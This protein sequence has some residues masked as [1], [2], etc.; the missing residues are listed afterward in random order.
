MQ[1]L[2]LLGVEVHYFFKVLFFLLPEKKHWKPNL[3]DELCYLFRDHDWE[4]L[5]EQCL[6]RGIRLH[7]GKV[8]N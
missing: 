7:K 2:I 6:Q 3:E 5:V 8:K 4:E 1:Q